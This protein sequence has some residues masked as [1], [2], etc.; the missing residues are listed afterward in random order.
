[1]IRNVL[2]T[3]TL[4]VA[5][6]LLFLALNS[7]VLRYALVA[8]VTVSGSSMYPAIRPWDM[9]L[10]VSTKLTGVRAGEVY[11]YSSRLGMYIVH[12]VINQ[13]GDLYLFKG[14]NNLHVDGYVS[15]DNIVC[16]VV[17]HFPRH[18]WVPMFAIVLGV[19]YSYSFSRKKRSEKIFSTGI[20][21]IMVL[22]IST[23]VFTLTEPS[24]YV[25]PNPV[26]LSSRVVVL[27]GK[28]Y[29]VIDNWHL[30]DSVECMDSSK[31]VPCSVSNGVVEVD[32]QPAT[33]TLLMKLRSCYNLVVVETVTTGAIHA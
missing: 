12:R 15:A 25:K 21:L 24:A 2:R 9:L 7:A 16:K 14:D 26:P 31:P 33:L 32:S 23:I 28:T 8:L 22:V 13:S 19:C 5:L 18:V 20:I 29:V 10:C 6:L 11:V 17:L 27:D 3:L 30:V 1:M 4:V